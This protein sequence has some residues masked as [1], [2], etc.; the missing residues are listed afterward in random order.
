MV[1]LRASMI[2]RDLDIDGSASSLDGRLRRKCADLRPGLFAINDLGTIALDLK[3][4]SVVSR[5]NWASFGPDIAQSGLQG[6]GTTN[7]KPERPC[8][9]SFVPVLSG[10]RRTFV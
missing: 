7:K 10:G 5:A 6:L 8:K 9:P 2:E 4:G 1:D 3:P